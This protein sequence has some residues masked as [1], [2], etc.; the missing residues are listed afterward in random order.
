MNFTAD[1]IAAIIP[2]LAPVAY[3]KPGQYLTSTLVQKITCLL[4]ANMQAINSKENTDSMGQINDL[5]SDA[6]YSALLANSVPYVQP[7]VVSPTAA[8]QGLDANVRCVEVY[9]NEH[10]RML[11]DGRLHAKQIANSQIVQAGNATIHL[12]PFFNKSLK[13]THVSPIV[14]LDHLVTTYV[15]PNEDMT[16]PWPTSLSLTTH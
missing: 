12:A 5:I 7:L 16:T 14:L 11:Q 3:H 1:T 10:G 6:D 8:I 15:T 9:E 2:Y 4:L 13:W